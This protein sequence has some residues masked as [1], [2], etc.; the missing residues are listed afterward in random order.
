MKDHETRLLYWFPI[1]HTP[2]DL[3][4]LREDVRDAYQ[5]RIGEGSWEQHI[6]L[7][8]EIWRSI[9]ERIGELGLDYKTTR[10]YQDGLPVCDHEAQI[11]A[12]LAKNGSVNHR[13]LV[14]LVAKGA[15]LMGTESPELLLSEYMNT[16]KLIEISKGSS[17]VP[18]GD[19]SKRYA[20]SKS[21]LEKRDRFIADRIARTLVP[22]ET[23]LIFL[24]MLH[25][26]DGRLPSDIQ[27]IRVDSVPSS[28]S[29][30]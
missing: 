25:S 20:A 30:I 12:D 19:A 3:G 24:G 11:V 5:K 27:V 18:R 7:V 2:A 21:L 28:P 23:G 15:I 8:D 9:G 13:I 16:K 17:S 4:S 1:I 14:D 6:K 10:L 29:S 26:L 22:G